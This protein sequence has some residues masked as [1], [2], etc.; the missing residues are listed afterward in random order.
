MTIDDCLWICLPHTDDDGTKFNESVSATLDDKRHFWDLALKE[1]ESD[2]DHW[3]PFILA[4]EIDRILQHTRQ[5]I[6][7]RARLRLQIKD[8]GIPFIHNMTTYIYGD[9]IAI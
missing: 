6:V 8:C 2:G 3:L 9:R 4:I 7:V 1:K 5:Q